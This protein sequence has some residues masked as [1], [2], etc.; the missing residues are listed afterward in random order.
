MIRGVLHSVFAGGAL[1]ALAAGSTG[2]SRLEVRSDPPGAA[3]LWSA[4]GL[5]PYHPWPPKSWELRSSS[6]TVTEAG[7]RARGTFTPFKTS[8]FFG[9]T[10]FVTV[11]KEGYRRPLPQAVQ[12][13]AWR[14]PEVEFRLRELPETV[15][16]RMTD[17]GLVLYNGEWV[18]PE[19]EGLEEYQGVIM[20]KE[21]A[22]VLRQ[23]AAGLVLYDGDWMTP[24]EAT[25]REAADMEARGMVRL[26]GR[27][28]SEAVYEEETVTDRRAA[29]VRDSKV[30]PDLPAPRILERTNLQAAEVQVTNSTGQQV[31]FLF[32]GPRSRTLLLQP[33]QSAGFR[34][35]DRVSFP[36]GTYDIVAIPTGRDGSG[37]NLQEVLG[38]SA[39]VRA[40]ALRTEP[41]WAEW[42]LAAGTRYSF[43]FGSSEEEL[44]MEADDLDSLE[45]ELRITPPELEIPETP[46]TRRQQ[47]PQGTRPNGP[48]GGPGG[49]GAR[50][51]AGQ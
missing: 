42:P 34:A 14:R 19:K 7:E 13:Y 20:A 25:T 33:Y 5:E 23:R 29:Q 11:E 6:E 21:E 43:N 44:Q 50:P 26:K 40:V 22:H 17:M 4:D 16:E 35:D 38:S 41:A 32:S 28:V 48:G 18:D 27:W 24:E 49:G 3:V 12:L 8:G 46:P 39:N 51:G 37:R 36:P 15:A 1:A 31:E 47:R 45:P 10:V 9:D 2:C 30:Y